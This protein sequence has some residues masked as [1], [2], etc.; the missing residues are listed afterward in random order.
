MQKTQLLFWVTAPLSGARRNTAS[1]LPW[2]IQT[3]IF[4]QR[5]SRVFTQK[6]VH[7]FVWCEVI[8]CIQNESVFTYF[9][10]G[11]WRRGWSN[12]PAPSSQWTVIHI[13]GGY[14]LWLRAFVAAPRCLHR[15]CWLCVSARKSKPF[16]QRI[17]AKKTAESLCFTKQWTQPSARRS[18]S[19][20]VS[21]T[22]EHT[23][24]VSLHNGWNNASC[25][26][27]W[28]TQQTHN[29]CDI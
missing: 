18:K 22:E 13:H 4:R 28:D 9:S 14:E 8:V 10:W 29:M 11:I 7:L 23:F 21:P 6:V 20:T 5:C 25:S 19:P 12:V 15:L 17:G 26:R 3:H 27:R 1:V 2:I 24:S 16:F